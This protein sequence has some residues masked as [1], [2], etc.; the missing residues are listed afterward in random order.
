[1]IGRL[2]FCGPLGILL[3]LIPV[4]TVSRHCDTFSSL[5]SCA[6]LDYGC[7]CACSCMGM[8]I[9][10]SLFGGLDYWTHGK[11][12]WRIKEQNFRTPKS[13]ATL[14]TALQVVQFI[15]GQLRYVYR[16]ASAIAIA[17]WCRPESQAERNE[18]VPVRYR[19]NA[20]SGGWSY[21]RGLVHCRED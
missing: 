8:C 20:A 19:P 16:R 3:A 1:M 9:G 17:V 15:Q 13:L 4:C 11:C 2:S 18:K 6:Q 5:S 7:V 10:P 21:G 12:L 14:P